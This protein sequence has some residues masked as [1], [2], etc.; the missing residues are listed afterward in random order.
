MLGQE[1]GRAFD[2]SGGLLAHQVRVDLPRHV[3]RGLPEDH[4]NDLNGHAASQEQ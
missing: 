2:L 1:L 4:L 3:G